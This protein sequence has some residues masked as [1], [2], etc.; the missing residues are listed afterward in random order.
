LKIFWKYL[1]IHWFKVAIAVGFLGVTDIAQVM[2]PGYVRQGLD[3]LNDSAVTIATYKHI[4]IMIAGLLIVVAAT[5]MVWR[6]IMWPMSRTVGYELRGELFRHLQKL[7]TSYY[8]KH[9]SGDLMS[10]ANSDVDAIRMF[11]SMGFVVFF[12]VLFVMPLAIYVMLQANMTMGLAIAIPILLAP[13]F[14]I[15]LTGKLSR[16]FRQSQEELG[17][18]SGRVQEDITGTRVIKTYARE[19]AA[20]GNYMKQN[21]KTRAR[22]LVVSRLFSL[23]GPYFH[24]V[25]QA[26]I[27]VLVLVCTTAAMAGKFTTGEMV[28]MHI[29]AGLLSWPTFALGWGVTMLQRMRASLAR[30]QEVFDEPLRQR[31]AVDAGADSVGGD[32][33]FRDLS[34][35]YDQN[36]SVIKELNLE[37]KEGQVLGLTGPTGCGKTTLLS[38][39]VNLLEAPRGRI[40]LDDCDIREI[41][42]EKLRRHVALVQQTPYLFSRSLQENMAFARPDA[43]LDDVQE[44]VR[45]AGLQPDLNQFEDGLD[46]L[47]GDRGLTLSGGQR[48]RVAL[49][50]ALVARPQVL[51]LDDAFAAVDVQT[52][53][54]VWT[55]LRE[56]MAG[57]TIIVVSHRISVL[58]RCDRI[59]VLEQGRISQEGSHQQLLKTDGFYSRTF[60]LQEL[61]ES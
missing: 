48:L 15:A 21:L 11:F 13:I 28:Q 38:L 56:K 33:A 50:R 8:H 25:P 52:E 34:F 36:V 14:S 43:D 19:E 29:F 4:A 5:R 24:V 7:D 39:A 40:F 23:I 16:S 22:F 59:A 47:V 53:E 12:D 10:R 27:L 41:S 49:G 42:P 20:Y 37:I 45:V 31:A 46:T 18:L 60:A 55:G 30:V 51:L 3:S 1:R 9:S 17:L 57:R 2:I 6:L 44:A 35:N 58:R 26:A 61:F 54:I 32:L